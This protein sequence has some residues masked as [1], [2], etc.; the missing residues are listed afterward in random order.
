LYVNQKRPKDI[1]D[2]KEGF[3]IEIFHSKIDDY[4]AKISYDLNHGFR[5]SK[6]GMAQ[7]LG[8]CAS[9]IS[10]KKGRGRPRPEE[11]NI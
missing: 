1:K 10:N 7:Q 8:G 3:K 6:A 4:G 5:V 9:T 2:I 11:V